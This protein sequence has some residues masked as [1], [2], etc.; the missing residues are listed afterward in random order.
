MIFGVEDFLV[1]E[2]VDDCLPVL[3]DVDFLLGEL[4][5]AFSVVDFDDD[6]SISSPGL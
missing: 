1:V 6:A 4:R 3:V 5:D 2:R